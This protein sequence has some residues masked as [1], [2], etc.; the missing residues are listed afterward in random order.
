MIDLHIDILSLSNS[1]F[2]AAEQ[3]AR[4]FSGQA[5]PQE[6]HTQASP[7]QESLAGAV[8]GAEASQR[9]AGV[10]KDTSSK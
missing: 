9:P 10:L 1:S 5:M 8:G 4:M 2:S 6:G 3:Q 7:T